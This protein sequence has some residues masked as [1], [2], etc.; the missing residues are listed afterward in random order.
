M[1]PAAPNPLLG[2]RFFLD[3]MEPAYMQWVKWKRA[4]ETTKAN[5]IWK[6]AREPRFRWFGKF[7]RAADAEEGARLPRPR[8]VRPARHACR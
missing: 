5:M 3:R 8:A 7:T 6:L 1:D 2:Q 4:G